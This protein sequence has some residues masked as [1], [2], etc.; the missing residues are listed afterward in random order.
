MLAAFWSGMEDTGTPETPF[1]PGW[2]VPASTPTLL[3]PESLATGACSAGLPMSVW[4]GAFG[5]PAPWAVKGK[6]QHC[7]E[8]DLN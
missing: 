3:T 6:G 8:D 7:L 2:L 1:S 5:A 4:P